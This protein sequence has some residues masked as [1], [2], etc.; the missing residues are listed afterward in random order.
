MD[1]IFMNSED[2]KT[3]EPHKPSHNVEDEMNFIRL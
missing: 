3:S 1:I 2:N